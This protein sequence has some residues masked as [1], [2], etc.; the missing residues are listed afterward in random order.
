MEGNG[1]ENLLE[2]AYSRIYVSA[3]IKS[4]HEGS[5]DQLLEDCD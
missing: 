1:H 2:M 4:I 3:N 5:K